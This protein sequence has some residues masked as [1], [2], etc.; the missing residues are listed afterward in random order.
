MGWR[1]GLQA[2]RRAKIMGFFGAMLNAGASV[3]GAVIGSSP[4]TEFGKAAEAGDEAKLKQMYETAGREFTINSPETGMG[5]WSNTALHKASRAGTLGCVQYLLSQGADVNVKNDYSNTPLHYA[6]REHNPAFA[7][8]KKRGRHLEIAKALIVEGA[9]VNAIGEYKRTPLLL[10][11]SK[12]IFEAAL[13]QLMAAQHKGCA[14]LKVDEVTGGDAAI[15]RACAEEQFEF[16]SVLVEHG[17]NI[18]LRNKSRDTPLSLVARLAI[19]ELVKLLVAK[20]ADVTLDG[21]EGNTPLYYFTRGEHYDVE[22]L[23]LLT[24]HGCKG[25]HLDVLAHDGT[26]ALH[27]AYSD[28]QPDVVAMLLEGGADVNVQAKGGDTA[29]HIVA[30][31]GDV[32]ACTLL[33]SKGANASAV[34]KGGATPLHLACE[35]GSSEVRTML[36]AAGAD[37]NAAREDGSTPLYLVCHDGQYDLEA[38]QA[39]IACG[40]R[41]DIVGGDG[42]AALHWAFFNQRSDVV[43]M[44][45]EG[46]ADVNVQAK[47]GDTA[48]HI[49]AGLGDV[50]A[51][52]LLLSKGANASAVGKGGA[53]P[54]HL[55]CEN[56]STELATMLLAAGADANAAR[57]D[58]STPLYLVCHDGHFDIDIVRLL[59][60]HE[61]KPDASGST[62][63]T[64]LHEACKCGQFEAA[65]MLLDRGANANARNREK[66]TPL[67]VAVDANESEMAKLVIERGADVNAEGDHGSPF[68]LACRNDAFGI[69][70]L[71][72]DKGASV[73]AVDA[74][75]KG[76][77]DHPLHWACRKAKFDAVEFLV[78]RGADVEAK[79]AKGETPLSIAE[80]KKNQDIMQLLMNSGERGFLRTFYFVPSH[81]V[82]AAT[83]TLPRMQELRAQKKLEKIGVDI[84]AAITEGIKDILFISHRWESFKVP[85]TAGEQFAAIQAYLR[86]HPEIKHV[87]YDVSTPPLV[88][89]VERRCRAFLTRPPPRAC[90]DA[91]SPKALRPCPISPLMLFSV[92]GLYIVTRAV[93]VYAARR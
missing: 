36:L 90:A 6:L 67:F 64:A 55:A 84:A 71:L 82:L 4:A 58:G 92:H 29:L 21:R 44:L 10:V 5:S 1:R 16:V 19:K 40:A 18:N 78:K 89:R 76:G 53:T 80:A 79:N 77:G 73:E 51:C 49:V 32:E 11:S 47:G 63:S 26:A 60:S 81:I 56:A 24:S 15:H 87:W 30:G 52:T 62:G 66:D 13:V 39:L 34:G 61:A 42:R 23:K 37:A 50:E 35:N 74:S 8:K 69:A 72:A 85:D 57:E 17:A 31:L 9:D 22:M 45:L 75:K 88:A 93:L 86:Q 83:E 12:P 7:E 3:V 46:G 91:S 59:L 33:L 14:P 68:F 43:T 70:S 65:R 48:L 41:G 54:L 27:R 25:A 28:K 2:A 38:I 20:G